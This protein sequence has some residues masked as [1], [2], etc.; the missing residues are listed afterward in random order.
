MES[1]SHRNHFLRQEPEEK[2]EMPRWNVHA[3]D[4]LRN[5][6]DWGDDGDDGSCATWLYGRHE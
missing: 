5:L 6:P 2:E 3:L 4:I 1:I